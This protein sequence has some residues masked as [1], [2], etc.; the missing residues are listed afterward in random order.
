MSLPFIPLAE[1]WLP[2][3]TAD[4]VRD[5]IRS[6]FVGPG[7]RTQTF[8]DALCG[9]TGAAHCSL[10]T[11]GTIALSVAAHAIQLRPG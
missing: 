3:D 2:P 8:A 9:L 1:P 11:S 10:T 5:Q 7:Q 4:A 6:G